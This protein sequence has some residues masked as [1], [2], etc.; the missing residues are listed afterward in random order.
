MREV[1]ATVRSVSATGV[2]EGKGFDARGVA[3]EGEVLRWYRSR[4]IAYCD[5]EPV[6]GG[7]SEAQP[8]AGAVC[9]VGDSVRAG[10]GSFSAAGSTDR[11]GGSG[12]TAG[13]PG[14]AVRV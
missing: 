1:Y 10:Y 3:A 4:A 6:A 7:G 11:A 2:E 13:S 9:A 14:G 8:A 5:A 12:D